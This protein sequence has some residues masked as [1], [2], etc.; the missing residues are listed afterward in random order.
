MIRKLALAGL[1]LCMGVAIAWAQDRAAP[2][3]EPWVAA[4]ELL[5]QA[6]NGMQQDGF[7]G[8]ARHALAIEKS[9]DEA[10]PLFPVSAAANGDIVVLTDGT[11]E[12]LMALAP[13]P[14]DAG[15]RRTALENPYPLLG[16]LLGSLYV[17]VGRPD[18]ALRVL[19]LGLSLSPLPGAR[20]G[21]TVPGLISER[22]AALNALKRYGD[23]LANYEDGLKITSLSVIDQGRLHR[24]RG[25]A[26]TELGR[27]DD[28]EAAYREA[29]KLDPK[30]T[31]AQHELLY[32]AGLRAGRP[33]TEGYLS[34]Q[35]PASAEQDAPRPGAPPPAPEPP[36]NPIAFPVPAAWSHALGRFSL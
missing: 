12:T 30:D 31:R 14:E 35:P 32:I 1:A 2:A 3:G 18:D 25:Y 26:L 11:T 17:E 8:V 24:G 15:K 22:G 29:L 23:S 6:F 33:A 7:R 36:R 10:A 4:Q 9:L 19:D 5:A 21:R 20:L 28:A 34:T 13:A 16:L 27:L